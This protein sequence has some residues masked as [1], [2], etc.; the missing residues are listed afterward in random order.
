M[1][2]NDDILQT[3]W[4]ISESLN[5]FHDFELFLARFN[6]LK[7]ETSEQKMAANALL[8][9]AMRV[10]REAFIDKAAEAGRIM[11][12]LILPICL[13][14]AG[15]SFNYPLVRL[16]DV[17]S[18]LADWLAQ[19]THGTRV[20]LQTR[21]YERI[22]AQEPAN[23][24]PQLRTI[25]A[26]GSRTQPVWTW[27][28]GISARHDECGNVALAC[29]ASMGPSRS[30]RLTLARSILF[31][32]KGDVPEALDYAIYRLAD[33]RFVPLIDRLTTAGQDNNWRRLSALGRIADVHY[34]VAR[35]QRMVWKAFERALDGPNRASILFVGG[36]LA[37]CDHRNV[38]RTLLKLLLKGGAPRHLLFNQLEACI[39][40]EQLKGWNSHGRM[41]KD[42]IEKL[43]TTT[44]GNLTRSMT[45]EDM[46]RRQAWGIGLS[47]GDPRVVSW[48]G[49]ALETEESPLTAGEIMRSVSCLQFKKLPPKV[50]RFAMGPV[51]AK[52]GTTPA[53]LGARL[54][55]ARLMH[56]RGT[57]EALRDLLDFSCTI[58]GHP[59]RSIS[60]MVG[61]LAW[62]LSTTD[63]EAVLKL[64]IEKATD[65][66]LKNR[67]VVA[68]SG[69]KAI[70]EGLSDAFDAAALLN[71]VEDTSLPEYALV[72]I[73]DV[74]ARRP[75]L[76]NRPEVV[77]VFLA[78]LNRK[79]EDWRVTYS[80][81]DA[82]VAYGLA[83][84]YS[85]GILRSLGVNDLT[86]EQSTVLA[87]WKVMVL[88]ELVL[89]DMRLLPILKQSISASWNPAMVYFLGKLH[90]LK[91][92]G[93][94]IPRRL[95]LWAF[96]ETIRQ[97][98]PDDGGTEQ[99]KL[100]AGLLPKDFARVQWRA[101]WSKWMP[102]VRAALA[103][104]LG[105]AYAG[106]P[107]KDRGRLFAN[108]EQLLGDSTYEVRRSSARTLVAIDPR[109]LSEIVDTWAASGN[110]DLR[111]KASEL[112]RWLPVAAGET[113]LEKLTWDY[114]SDVRRA[115]G[116][117]ATE[118]R[119][120][121]FAAH[122]RAKI[123]S[124]RDPD[125]NR[126]VLNA[127]RYGRA[128]VALGDLDAKE[129]L[130]KIRWDR[131]TPANVANW[132]SGLIEEIEKKFKELAQKWPQPSFA[133]S[134]H[135]ENISSGVVVEGLGL[136][137]TLSLWRSTPTSPGTLA[138]WGGAFD[139]PI[140][141]ILAELL[142]NRSGVA[143][144]LTLSIKRRG[145]R[146]ILVTSGAVGG[147]L[148]FVGDG[149]YPAQTKKGR[150][151]KSRA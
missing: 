5:T 35:V 119:N 74:L 1:E 78:G 70:A 60:E 126:W 31:R 117:S 2:N 65:K 37:S 114:D 100:L 67:R 93:L 23:V 116:E 36:A 149:S 108:L 129:E 94:D 123:V 76:A 82:L 132:I 52:P 28:E 6:T 86:T 130:D 122:A 33:P 48:L 75:D 135:L 138:S 22:L 39:R 58:D 121:A 143:E 69:I 51:D 144:K 85:A 101:H 49:L 63:G 81:C 26:L 115:A 139:A 4:T 127:Y 71:L 18:A 41:R 10:L 87:D 32:S 97:L 14:Q 148:F 38:V 77:S 80:A 73:I 109:R 34:G 83:T 40:P 79:A 99:F 113:A 89:T 90:S 142:L 43:A 147:R 11:T 56:S 62:R 128:L 151:V 17:R 103:D 96:R 19:Y 15:G 9:Q 27:L 12:D 88:T 150:V 95:V 111:R 7:S 118:L 91:E 29:L 55:A 84:T 25:V 105:V 146:R 50:R 125:G 61:D 54:A 13:E 112:A 64:L 59:F 107:Q 20:V 110:S 57:R 141:G 53:D 140:G 47:M 46:Q 98:R 145:D 68:I 44:T 137:S 131:R 16:T 124:S 120:R 3:L 72:E 92:R 136:E 24:L 30:E 21:L 133:W 66:S 8:S 104:A 134:G 106:V 42:S 102:S 45:F